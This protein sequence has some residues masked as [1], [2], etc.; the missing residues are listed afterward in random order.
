LHSNKSF[1]S[2]DIGQHFNNVP[3][4]V[5]CR[6]LTRF[7]TKVQISFVFV[8]I[9]SSKHVQ[10]T[11]TGKVM[12][13]ILQGSA[14]TQTMLTIY[15]PVANLCQKLRKLAG[16]RQ[17]YCKNYQAYFFGP[18]CIITFKPKHCTRKAT[19]VLSSGF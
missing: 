5:L 17:S 19:S 2:M 16:S 10:S 13:K 14:V 4:S 9:N 8:I 1:M 3:L 11:N 7:V 6:S 15:P 12:I 18:P